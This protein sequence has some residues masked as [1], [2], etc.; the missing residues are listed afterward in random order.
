M[1]KQQKELLVNFFLF[2]N[3]GDHFFAPPLA[4]LNLK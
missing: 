2:K 4:T 3:E 1:Q